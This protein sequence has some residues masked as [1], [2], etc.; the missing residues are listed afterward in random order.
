M[1]ISHL[2]A[3]GLFLVGLFGVVNYRQQILIL[4]MSLELMLLA[5]NTNFIAFSLT[6]QDINGQLVVFFIMAVAAAEVA[7][8]L[9]LLVRLFRRLNNITLD[10]IT[11]LRG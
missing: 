1:M 9:A 4:L 7:I 2:Y 3:I 5:I 11:Q 8:G 6:H 10:A